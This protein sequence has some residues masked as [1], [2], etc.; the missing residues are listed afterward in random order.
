MTI[1]VDADGVLEN[2]TSEILSLLNEKYGTDVKFENMREWGFSNAFPELT[3]EQIASAE[4]EET[5]YERIRPISGAPDYLK[6]LMD[7]GN[8]VYIVT[9]TPYEAVSFKMKKVMERFFPFLPWENFIITAKKQMIRGDVLIDDGI[10]NLVGGEYRKILF[11]APYNRTYDAE[12]NGMIRVFSW[13][14]IYETIAQM[15]RETNK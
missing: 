10:H 14:E 13:K 8:S 4:R 7:E 1:L 5:L 6:K 9:N 3:R 15:R 11:D 12:A 2:L